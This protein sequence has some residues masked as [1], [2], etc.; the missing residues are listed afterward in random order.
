MYPVKDLTAALAAA[1]PGAEIAVED[2][3]GTEDHYK[4]RIVAEVFRG[5]TAV[6]QHRLVYG[7]LGDAMS[8]PIHALSLRTFTPEA[9]AESREHT[10]G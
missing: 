2:L 6:E 5:K 7:A 4:A 1:F 9:W 3:T 10:D 8:G